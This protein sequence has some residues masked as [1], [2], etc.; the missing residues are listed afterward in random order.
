MYCA[1]PNLETWLRACLTRKGKKWARCIRD[2]QKVLINPCC[3]KKGELWPIL[4][5]V[6]RKCLC[7]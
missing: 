4:C 7:P 5:C 6:T 1:S 3:G 2:I